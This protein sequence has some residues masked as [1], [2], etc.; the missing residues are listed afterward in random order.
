MMSRAKSLVLTLALL[1]IAISMLYANAPAVDSRRRLS[2]DANYLFF[3]MHQTIRDNHNIDTEDALNMLYCRLYCDD[4]G[5]VVS[6]G[7]R[8]SLLYDK[9]FNSWTTVRDSNKDRIVLVIR[10][11]IDDV[12]FFISVSKNGRRR[13]LTDVERTDAIDKMSIVGRINWD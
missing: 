3:G 12:D 2:S 4:R 13:D 7:R 5:Q 11:R 9:D 10:E 8:V 6:G 1:I